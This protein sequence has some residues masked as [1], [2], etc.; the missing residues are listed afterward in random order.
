MPKT[1]KGTFNPVI[2]F[3]FGL[4]VGLGKSLSLGILKAEISITIFGIIEGVIAA[5]R[6]Y[7]AAQLARADARLLPGRGALV[8]QGENAR[9]LAAAGDDTQY[10]FWIRGTIGL[11]G[12]INGV[13]DFAIVK[14]EIAIEVR[15]FIQVTFEAYAEVQI[16]LEA[17]VSVRISLSINL[18]LFK[19]TI[20]LS[21]SATVRES[22]IIGTDR[23]KEAPWY[24]GGAPGLAFRPPRL[25]FSRRDAAALFAAAPDFA[26]L[27]TPASGTSDLQIYFLPQPTV[28][29]DTPALRA[30]QVA[31]LVATSFMQSPGS[32]SGVGESA[33][34]Q[35]THDLFLW[36]GSSFRGAVTKPTPDGEA[37]GGVQ[38]A[39]A[40]GRAG[41]PRRQR[42]R[43]AVHLWP[44]HR[45]HRR[46][47]QAR[48]LRAAQDR[49]RRPGRAERD[50][51]PDHPR[52]EPEG[53]VQ[54]V[55]ARRRRLQRLRHGRR[56][57]PAKARRLDRPPGREISRRAR[58]QAQR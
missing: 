50:R 24:S 18:G 37:K 46:S 39:A 20:N 26:P 48:R 31:A 14:A 3:G 4:Q 23:R 49:R 47:G 54:A 10:Y 6:P 36:I 32:Q 35:L 17:G 29:N 34:E 9:G 51:L 5:W 16:Y 52:A 25:R 12:K 1:D 43:A 55:G 19:I 27:A 40:E 28:Y 58:A 45:R 44:A 56:R 38:P 57:L 41:V 2:E 30:T 33:F 42:Q 7:A 15:A 11:L 13:V 53:G 22:F 8:P 21:F